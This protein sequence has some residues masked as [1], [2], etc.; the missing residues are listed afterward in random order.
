[1][2]HPFKFL[3]SSLASLKLLYMCFGLVAMTHDYMVNQYH[4]SCMPCLQPSCHAQLKT[5]GTM[6]GT[7]SA[8]Y[9]ESL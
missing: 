5:S 9:C 3:C 7:I 8:K 1:M 6:Q 4:Q 2:C